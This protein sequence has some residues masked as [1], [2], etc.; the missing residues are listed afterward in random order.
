M[1][2][3][4]FKP[5]TW[6]SKKQEISLPLDLSNEKVSSSEKEIKP[7]NTIG[8]PPIDIKTKIIPYGRR[9][10]KIKVFAQVYHGPISEKVPAKIK[11]EHWLTFRTSD[12]VKHEKLIADPPK[13]HE[14]IAGK[15]FL[16]KRVRELIFH[17]GYKAEATHD[18]ARCQYD[19]PIIEGQ[20]K[21]T[22]SITKTDI[23]KA[24]ADQVK[25]GLSWSDF[26]IPAF[27]FVIILFLI[28]AFQVQP[29]M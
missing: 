24:A 16:R 28:F 21:M 19:I 4:I 3:R 7:T 10:K 8:D 1:V 12:R 9:I 18:P 26:V 23:L 14:Y 20:I 6:R 2:W 27:F 29:N 22:K 17:V 13:T 15:W 25:A 11:N 5:W